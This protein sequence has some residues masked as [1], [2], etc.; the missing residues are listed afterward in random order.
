MTGLDLVAVQDL[1]L[2]HVETSFPNYQVVEDQVLDDESIIKSNNRV[3]PYIVLRW[4]GL[5]RS[6]TSGS[7]GGVRHDE[8]SSSVDVI[9]VAPS[10]RQARLGLNLVM[11]GLI[12]WQ[13]PGGSMLAPVG[14][15]S[16]FSVPDY[17]GKPHVY[18]AIN[19]LSFQVNSSNV[20]T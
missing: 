7:F 9:L 16:L 6:L 5:N 8:Y 15:Q 19:T 20:G 10:P 14:G 12:G 4:H 13:V 3:K 17:D 2:A 18:M 11:D 1:I